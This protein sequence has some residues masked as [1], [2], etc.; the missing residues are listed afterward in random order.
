MSG[1]HRAS[2]KILN[3][4]NKRVLDVGCSYGWFEKFASKDAKEIIGIDLNKEDIG[5]AK[6]A[7]A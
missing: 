7:S 1:R 5:I 4:K 6:R 2:L 3:W